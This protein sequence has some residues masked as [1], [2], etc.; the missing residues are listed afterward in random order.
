MG[1]V[2]RRLFELTAKGS[3][4]ELESLELLPQT[5]YFVLEFRIPATAA[6]AVCAGGLRFDGLLEGR[7]TTHQV[8]VADLLG[9]GRTWQCRD[10]GGE[11]VGQVFEH[12]L[13]GLGVVEPV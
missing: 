7:M 12:G 10:H 8:H 3:K 11:L 13:D 2:V 5:P 4:V 9:A 1:V 6:T